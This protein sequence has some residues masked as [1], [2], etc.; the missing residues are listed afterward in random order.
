MGSTGERFRRVMSQFAS[1]IRAFRRGTSTRDE[2]LAAL[3]QELTAHRTA[4]DMLLAILHSEDFTDA[5]PTDVQS[6]VS[7]RITSWS[8]DKTLALNRAATRSGEAENPQTILLG[9]QGRAGPQAQES[10]GSPQPDIGVGTVLQGRFKLI[11]RIGEGGMSRVYKAIDLR[12]VE[13]RSPNPFLAVKVLTVPSDHYVDSI[14]TLAREADN[15]RRLTHPNIVRVID[16][17]RDGATV[18]M[19]MEFL[20]GESLHEHLKPAK[21]NVMSPAQR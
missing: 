19:T 14:Q 18:F 4:P 13:A 21:F 1:A 17:D 9:E 10:A 11:E 8:E 5:L 16:V 15:L 6:A 12:R 20:S 7:E 2:L 3:D